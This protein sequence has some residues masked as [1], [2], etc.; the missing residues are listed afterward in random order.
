MKYILIH[1]LIFFSFTNITAQIATYTPQDLELFTLETRPIEHRDRG[2]VSLSDIFPLGTDNSSFTLPSF[3]TNDYHYEKYSYNVLDSIYRNQF[4]KKTNIS[5][6][7]KVFIY[8]Y[9]KDILIEVQVSELKVVAWLNA[10]TSSSECPCP[11][12]YYQ[13]GLEIKKIYLMSL[14]NF[15]VIH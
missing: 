4:L 1:F 9:S 6:K 11:L 7:D 15:T 2:F 5:E 8:S 13:I 12:N 10:Y 14:K 3:D